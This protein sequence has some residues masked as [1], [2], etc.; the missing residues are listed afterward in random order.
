MTTEN[1]LELPCEKETCVFYDTGYCAID[2]YEC[3]AKIDTEE[4]YDKDK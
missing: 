4:F 3:L 1:R 2:N